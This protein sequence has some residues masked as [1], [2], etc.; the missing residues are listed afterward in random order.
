M[1]TATPRVPLAGLCF[2]PLSEAA[3]VEAVV[4]GAL[5]GRGGWVCPVNLDVLRQCDASEEVR[6]LVS[7]A[8][9]VVPDGM[10]LIWASRLAG[11]PLPERVAG[12]SLI[13][14]VTAYAASRP[15]R[16][17]FLGG[18]EGAAEAAAERLAREHPGLEVVRTLCPPFG[19]ERDAAALEEI[20]AA[21]LAA[22]P[23]V[24]FVGLG[25]PKQERLIERLRAVH[26]DAW[27]LSCG[28]SFSFA[29]GQIPRAPAW[30]QR[31]G[32]EWLHRLLQE[33]GRLSRRYLI[34]GPPFV[35]RLFALVLRDRA[36]RAARRAR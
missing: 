24:V 17:F 30:L 10:P 14:S 9:L 20:D 34:D 3:V 33:P 16:L 29:G 22:R 12:S 26:P 25:F 28:I 32:L 13:H 7:K 2:D 11:T 8:D 35:L 19:F 18:S 36:R 5:A 27:Y 21:I 1:S 15:A 23:H 31:V 6:G 4:D